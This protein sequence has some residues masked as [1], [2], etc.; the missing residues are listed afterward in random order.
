MKSVKVDGVQ[1]THGSGAGFVV[2]G[3]LLQV[4][5]EAGAKTN[6]EKTE[7]TLIWYDADGKAVAKTVAQRNWEPVHHDGITNG[8]EVDSNGNWVYWND[9]DEGSVTITEVK[10]EEDETE[11]FHTAPGQKRGQPAHKQRYRDTFYQAPFFVF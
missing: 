10:L 11:G 1:Y 6:T 8:G 3:S 2:D 7:W 4:Q 5:V 9:T